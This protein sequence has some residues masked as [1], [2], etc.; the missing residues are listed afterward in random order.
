MVA[1][2]HHNV[3]MNPTA[4]FFTPLAGTI[5]TVETLAGPIPLQ[6]AGCTEMPRRGL[7]DTFRAPLSLIF[8]GPQQPVLPQDNYYVD[9]PAMDRQVWCIAP[10]MPPVPGTARAIAT[11][12]GTQRYQVLFT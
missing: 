8:S 12:P 1:A 7:P 2:V 6:L 9:H 11:P 5:F 3:P 10:T 4:E